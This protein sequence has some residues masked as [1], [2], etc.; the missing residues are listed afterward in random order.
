MRMRIRPNDIIRWTME[1]IGL[2]T[3]VMPITDV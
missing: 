1:E 3:V 2:R